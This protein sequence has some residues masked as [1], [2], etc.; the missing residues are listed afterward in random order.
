MLSKY[1][2]R[3]CLLF[4]TMSGILTSAGRSIRVY[5]T[6]CLSRGGKRE[7]CEST[8][9][10]RVR[11][12]SQAEIPSRRSRE[13]TGDVRNMFCASRILF[14]SIVSAVHVSLARII[15][16]NSFVLPDRTNS[17]IYAAGRRYRGEWFVPVRHRIRKF[18]HRAVA[19]LATRGLRRAY[20]LAIR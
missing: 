14:K 15:P 10:T 1:S 4:A 11:N 3:T 8:R 17:C 19:R 16:R 13:K 6:E 12:A 7:T 5:T 20:P 2:S 9:E 18:S